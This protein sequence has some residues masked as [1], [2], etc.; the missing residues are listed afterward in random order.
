[1]PWDWNSSFFNQKIL[2]NL[3]HSGLYPGIFIA[4][5]I[6]DI[7]KIFNLQMAILTFSNDKLAA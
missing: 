1:M 5:Q 7:A 2:T 3:L 4:K 6:R